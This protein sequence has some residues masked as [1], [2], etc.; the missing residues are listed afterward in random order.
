[1]TDLF[2]E[3]RSVWREEGFLA[4]LLM[5]VFALTM[6]IAAVVLMAVFPVLILLILGAAV[7]FLVWVILDIFLG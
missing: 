2:L 4:Q 3:L 5:T 7:G 1:M 6:L